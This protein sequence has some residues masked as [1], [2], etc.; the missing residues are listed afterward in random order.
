MSNRTH[1]RR[2]A[3]L[4]GIVRNIAGVV[5]E[6]TGVDDDK[7]GLVDL[8]GKWRDQ[9]IGE[10][11]RGGQWS[12]PT[13]E[14]CQKVL[15]SMPAFD[16]VVGFA[17]DEQHHDRRQSTQHPTERPRRSLYATVIADANIDHPGP[18]ET[19]YHVI[20]NM[21]RNL[22]PTLA[23]WF[24]I[25]AAVVAVNTMCVQHGDNDQISVSSAFK[26]FRR[27]VMLADS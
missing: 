9:V 2:V 17:T 19:E 7:V 13:Y 11:A 1:V 10:D 27:Q 3:E 8:V 12:K 21:P 26:G 18:I 25:W 22:A 20:V 5:L 15:E 24:D 23:S 16:Q 6:A 14:A 4:D